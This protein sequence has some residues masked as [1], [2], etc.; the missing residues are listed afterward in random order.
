MK[1]NFGSISPE[2]EAKLQKADSEIQ[3]YIVNLVS[4][5]SGLQKRNISLETKNVSLN[6]RVKA[7]ES[8]LKKIPTTVR[9]REAQL[10]ELRD[11]LAKLKPTDSKQH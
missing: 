5:V 7:L 6:E 8:E 3:Q 10:D 1:K 2:L 9:E 11:M 4:E